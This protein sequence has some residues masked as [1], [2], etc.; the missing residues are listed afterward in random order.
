MKPTLTLLAALLLTPLATLHAADALVLQPS[1]YVGAPKAEQSV[2]NRAFT[3]IP[4]IAVAPKGR[5]WA[6]WYAGV[7][8][9]EVINIGKWA[10]PLF[11]P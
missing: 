4:S 7:T 1:Q 5:M 3:G 8:P 9:G 6:T 10:V 2:T 11:L